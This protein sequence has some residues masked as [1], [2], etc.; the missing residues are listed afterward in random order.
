MSSRVLSAL[1]CSFI[2]TA[3]SAAVYQGNGIKI[4]EVTADSAVIWT[5]LTAAPEAN[6]AGASFLEPSLDGNRA[7]VRAATDVAKESAF[8]SAAE[9]ALGR[10]AGAFSAAALR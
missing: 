2:S 1:L 10:L 3:L 7:A 5:R 8:S 9:M 4:G 6:W